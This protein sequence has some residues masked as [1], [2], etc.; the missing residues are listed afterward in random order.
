[1]YDAYSG[2][3]GIKSE[4]KYKFGSPG[5]LNNIN[6]ALSRNLGKLKN[7]TIFFDSLS[8]M[9]DYSD[10][11]LAVDFVRTV[12]VKLQQG[13]H[14]AFFIIDSNA[15]D[16]KTLNYILHVMDGEIETVTETK[17]KGELERL[18]SFKRLKGFQVKPGY[19]E[20]K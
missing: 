8:T 15:H 12:K 11:E 3:S 19:H 6:L 9:I 5:E 14:V 2:V 4:E 17:K 20:L 7:A 16:E 1:M 10:L 18:V 13:G